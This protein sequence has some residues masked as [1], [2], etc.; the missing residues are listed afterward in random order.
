MTMLPDIDQTSYDEYEQQQLQQEIERKQQ[1][2]TLQNA[3]GEKIAGLQSIVG[4]AAGAVGGVFGSP[5]P[6]A[7]PMP[8][9]E[10][11]PTP[12][13]EPA[14]A[15]EPVPTPESPVDAASSQAPSV[16][17]P[18]PAPAP[19]AQP[20]PAVPSPAAPPQTPGPS[21]A[22][23]PSRAAA[24]PSSLQDWI[25]SAMGAAARSG[26]DLQKFADNFS[27]SGGDLAGNAIGAALRAGANMQTFTGSLGA[28]PQPVAAAPAPAFTGAVAAP[29]GD[30]IDYARAAAQRAGIDPDIFVRQIQQE[31]GFNPKAR[32]GAG[33]IGIAQFMPGT[34]AGMKVDP[35]DPYAALDA[36]AQMDAQNLNRY[37]SYDK[38]L[39]AYNAGGGAVEKYGG[40]P[41]YE[42]TQ[43]YVKNIMGGKDLPLIGGIQNA[44]EGATTVVR[45]VAQQ[46]SQFG[47]KQLTNDEAYAAC[48]PAAA[49]RFASMF[50]RNP[51]LREATDIARQVGWT[52][53][54]GM[55]GI[56]S[57][58]SL[59]DKLGV[60]TRLVSGP[61]WDQFAREAQSGNPV[62][63]S[64]QGHY[65]FADGYDP[66][67]GAFHVGRS[68]TDLKNGA[69]WM[70]PQQMTAVMGPVQGA[71]LADNPQVPAPS[72]ASTS[73][74]SVPSDMGTSKYDF[75][76]DRP[77]VDQYG[78]LTSAATG[79]PD[80]TYMG[81]MQAAS[82]GEPTPI[83]P[84]NIDLNNR[85]VVRNPDGSISTVRS[86]S[87]GTDRG[88]VLIPTV[89]DDGRILSNQEAI[90]QY[91]ATGKNLG[92]F[93]SPEAAT[94]YAQ[95]LHNQ[96]AQR[97][98]A[99]PAPEQSPVD[100]LKSAFGDFLDSLTRQPAGQPAQSQAIPSDVLTNPLGG[101]YTPEPESAQLTGQPS[102][103][104]PSRAGPA[105][106]PALDQ[107]QQ[108]LRSGDTQAAM[109]A[110]GQAREAVATSPV[111]T[112]LGTLRSPELM[113]D[114]EVLA[115]PEAKNTRAIWENAGVTDINDHNLAV[116]VRAA[117]LGQAAAMSEAGPEVSAA[118][119]FA[120]P[121]PGT[122]AV[123]ENLG[124]ARPDRMSPRASQGAVPQSG[125]E[126]LQSAMQDLEGYPNE[127]ASTIRAFAVSSDAP[128]SQV[129][130][131]I[132]RWME[133]NP[134]ATTVN[135]PPQV[136][137]DM[138]EQEL[139]A[140]LRNIRSGGAAAE[141]GQ[142][143]FD[144]NA[145][146][147]GAQPLLPE[148][149]GA[150]LS[151]EMLLPDYVPK[152]ELEAQRIAQAQ[153]RLA[154]MQGG[155]EESRAAR[156][157]RGEEDIPAS[158][159]MQRNMLGEEGQ[160][161][162]PRGPG[163]FQTPTREQMAAP[164]GML[165]QPLDLPQYMPKAVQDLIQEAHAR[166][167]AT[168][169][170]MSE[171]AWQALADKAGASVGRVQH[172]WNEKVPGNTDT[173]RAISRALD[174]SQ[175]ELVRTQQAL[176]LDPNDATARG[177]L[178]RQLAAH[179]ALQE[180]AEGRLSRA[181]SLVGELK[182][183]TIS[184]DKAVL[185][186]IEQ[187][188]KKSGDIDADAFMQRLLKTDM[189][190][191][192]K[193]AQ[194]AKAMRQ[195]SFGDKLTAWY[196]F[197]LLSDPATHARNVVGNVASSLGQV[198]ERVGS[199]LFDPAA[200][201][202]LGDEGPRQRYSGEAWANLQGMASGI[203]DAGRDGL[204]ALRYGAP[205]KGGEITRLAHEPFIGTPLEAIGYPGRALEAEDQ[206]F[207]GINRAG[208]LRAQA[209]RI[210]KQEG[211]EGQAFTD[212]VS[213]LISAPT[214][215]MKKAA[216]AR[217]EY[218]VFQ[219]NNAA[220]SKINAVINEWPALKAIVPFVRT[221]INMMQYILERSPAGLGKITYDSLFNRTA[222]KQA[223]SGELAD[224]MS[225]AAIGTTIMAGLGAQ[226]TVFDNLTGRAPTD[227]KDRDE[228]YRSGK[229]PY[230]FKNPVNGE[231]VSYLPLSPYAT[232]I[233]AA[234]DTAQAINDGKIKSNDASGIATTA[235][236][237]M[238][239]GL[240]NVQ[241]AQGLSD[242]LDLFTN[243][244]QDPL[245]DMQRIAAT[246]VASAVTP[247]L[248]RAVAR[249]TDSTL[250]D[251]TT[252]EFPQRVLESIEA[253]VPGLS[254]NVAPQ[255][256]AFGFERD[257]PNSGLSSIINP[258][259]MH[260]P[261]ND[262]V[263]NELKRLSSTGDLL[264]D[265]DVE[266]GL[267]GKNVNV[268]DKFPVQLTDDQQRR[269]QTQSGQLAYGILASEIDTP[270]WQ[271]LSDK[272]KAARIE[273]IYTKSREVARLAMTPELLPEAAKN[274]E[275][276]AALRGITLPGR[277]P[278]TATESEPVPAGGG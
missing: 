277:A 271:K 123:T 13:V 262:T 163:E 17:E 158:E 153:Q 85:P 206:F 172:V 151:P 219:N 108:A 37:G 45:G 89:S 36:A 278:S 32:S 14:P 242:V 198:P 71:L 54:S 98:G 88:E 58:K 59:M 62:T 4:G 52:S 269:Y 166:G 131:T 8:S 241:W 21:G 78:R 194:L 169:A 81:T 49:V 126:M 132:R 39:A 53:A 128:A 156:A 171:E 239:K 1:Q 142:L 25:T 97:Y 68:G 26:A 236:V 38:M 34:A 200:R 114:E 18:A 245:K 201:R 119:Q 41:P 101:R 231:W 182:P 82:V 80:R 165:T 70:T 214:E 29:G 251:P 152:S 161:P 209:Y 116:Y 11:A 51:S 23:P 50:G 66:Q 258:F 135:K 210:A 93:D 55:A 157:A 191:P 110:L 30:L 183:G 60:A 221:P 272:E 259:Y 179:Q 202:I 254:G 40:V 228:F 64:T 42:E 224:R 178:I 79:R 170:P 102:A 138:A 87:V 237:A 117:L 193:V 124:P 181:G 204:N 100:K 149:E 48:G 111:G 19:E 6:A 139:Q 140:N 208:D 75:Q 196:Y 263:E 238:A 130:S 222:L 35:T 159:L 125:A 235:A 233:G 83:E 133:D 223:G 74:T 84:G 173:A 9:P 174:D 105:V 2:F 276:R 107:A 213:Q 205:S 274:V 190:D 240:T 61:Q 27:T 180:A 122:R 244:T 120:R 148:G 143:G 203:G 144:E 252:D 99:A 255:V 103:A 232:L 199:A 220:A 145:F 127:V 106:L 218:Q 270:A 57:E 260:A 212:R 261:A 215:E 243:G 56:A 175:Q 69:E 177:E 246:N 195:Y 5:S 118:E 7:E 90:D 95:Q 63:I 104:L 217:A 275:N 226:A 268:L 216:E 176:K 28:P 24:P 15:P 10:P 253:N 22:P 44:V 266:P 67:S 129:A 147:R 96:Q 229:I 136:V 86:I 137:A 94:A 234:A 247:G 12:P 134:L 20:A 185:E 150:G 197:A 211:K 164:E 73:S 109:D 249:M 72:L 267:V 225:R 46:I 154:E 250:R 16:P 188:A 257:R 230:A 121:R 31:S 162:L 186:Q 248:I 47:D 113:S 3:I 146:G 168:G 227:P 189:T 167:L 91:R 92:V 77:L 155:I 65:F 184:G 265:Y 192:D 141:K 115:L 33:A 273:Q 264:K 256:D 160:A 112:V 76:I 187:M 43:R 207:R